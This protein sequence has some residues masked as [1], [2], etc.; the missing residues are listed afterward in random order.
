MMPRLPIVE[1]PQ[2]LDHQLHVE[3]F[4]QPFCG[5]I[6]ARCGVAMIG[7]G[8]TY[9]G[10]VTYLCHKNHDTTLPSSTRLD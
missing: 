8:I 4:K 1:K 7:D 3:G 6:K 9:E 2:V 10:N 5:L